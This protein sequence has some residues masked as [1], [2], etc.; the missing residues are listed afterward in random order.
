M[1]KMPRE[2]GAS[3]VGIARRKGSFSSIAHGLGRVN[4]SSDDG[5]CG[6][7]IGSHLGVGRLPVVM[8]VT[9]SISV[10]LVQSFTVAITTL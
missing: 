1:N 10:Y 4:V 8:V 5:R 2:G 9:C 6:R 3:P 7:D